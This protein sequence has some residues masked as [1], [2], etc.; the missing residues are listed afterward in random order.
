MRAANLATERA[1]TMT[2]ATA[3]HQVSRLMRTLVVVDERLAS[4]RYGLDLVQI[5]RRLED[6]L[7]GV[8][9]RFVTDPGHR[10]TNMGQALRDVGAGRLVLGL[11]SPSYSTVEVQAEA[12]LAGL[13][14]LGMQVVDLGG[15]VALVHPREA[16]TEK[17]MLLLAASIARSRTFTE[18]RPE[19]VKPHL[20]AAGSRRFALGLPRLEY[21]PVPWIDRQRCASERGCRLCVQACPRGALRAIEGEIRLNKAPCNAC[22]LC[23][24][25]CPRQAALIP[26]QE[27]SQLDAEIDALLDPDL[28]SLAPRGILFVCQNNV[29]G[30]TALTKTAPSY[31]AGWLPVQVPCVGVLSPVHLLRCVAAGAAAVAVVAPGEQCPPGQQEVVAGRV[32]FCREFL[33]LV[34]RPDVPVWLAPAAPEDLLPSLAGLAGPATGAPVPRPPVSPAALLLELAQTGHGSDDQALTHPHSPFGVVEVT[35]GCTGCGVCAEYCP[36]G[37]LELTH[38]G[39]GVSL[40][41]DAARCTACG[42]CLANCTEADRKVLRLH[43]AT[44]LRRL[45]SGRATLHRDLVR[46]CEACGQSNAP[47]ALLRRVAALLGGAPTTMTDLITRYC[48]SC[49]GAVEVGPR[50]VRATVGGRRG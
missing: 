29:A 45:A 19:M 2:M 34:G 40:T 32:A 28:A 27:A 4:P 16:A 17:A 8:A 41:F 39:D 26:N 9:V 6:Q 1:S 33:R 31:P 12:R 48:A 30:L 43:R 13:D 22:G 35:A 18:S 20:P 14:P 47:E 36:S 49:R 38:E 11:A 37:A 7:E 5:G 44:V 10:P 46:R 3:T 24:A 42:L 23:V 15:H 50:G 25:S 21:L